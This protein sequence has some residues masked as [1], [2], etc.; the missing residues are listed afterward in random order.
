[1]KVRRAESEHWSRVAMLRP[2]L[3]PDVFITRQVHRH[4]RWHVLEDPLSQRYFRLS[5]GAYRFV[6]HL[7]GR[8]SVEEAAEACREIDA[9]SAPTQDEV[10]HLLAGLHGEGLLT[11]D[12]PADAGALFRRRRRRVLGERRG[13][14]MNFLFMRI[15]LLDP[16]PL[17]DRLLPLTGWIFT[18]VGAAVWLLL[19]LSG[20]VVVMSN[21]RQVGAEA[22]SLL[23]LGRAPLLLL[24]FGAIKVCHEFGHGIACKKLCSTVNERG[25]REGGEVHRMGVM[26]LVL[27]PVPYVDASSAWRSARWWARA[28]VAAAG[29]WVELGIAAL[30]AFVWAGTSETSALH[31]VAFSAIFI[32]SVSTLLFNLNPLLRFDGYYILA[33]WLGMPNLA[34]RSR[35][36]MQWVIKRRVWGMR[37]AVN[38]ARTRGEA[39]IFAAYGPLSLVYRTVLYGSII[40][41]LADRVPAVGIA[42]ALVAVVVWVVTPLWRLLTTLTGAPWL[43]G[44]RGRAVVT[45]AL[46]AA[47]P[48]LLLGLIPAPDRVTIEGVVEAE[49]LMEVRAPFDGEVVALHERGGVEAGSIVVGLRNETMETELAALELERERARTAYRVALGE[50]AA[51]AALHAAEIASLTDSID[52]LASRLAEAEVHA[53]WAGRWRRESDAIRAGVRVRRGDLL[54]VVGDGSRVAIRAVAGQDVAMSLRAEG[55]DEVTVMARGAPDVRRAG[56]VE[57]FAPVAGDVLPHEALSRAAGGSTAMGVDERSLEQ[58]FEVRVSAEGEGLRPGQRVLVRFSRGA[59]PVAAQVARSVRQMLR[60]RDIL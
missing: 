33:D 35:E 17:L 13:R 41:L 43:D 15:P 52:W 3:R 30:A 14:V 12:V 16:D 47:A 54:G 4:E 26:L 24:T 23:S 5:E 20:V 49:R 22:A 59:R 31:G 29:M 60:R 34:Q 9:E 53:P 58:F 21:A 28:A 45:T 36:W 2:R 38:P 44:V 6:A 51:V 50:D 48:V 18:R 11:G 19:I 57:R 37:E 55:G 10:I 56:R 27:M 42:V 32:A 40:L 1:M 39:R 25:E 7:D 46:M 8:M